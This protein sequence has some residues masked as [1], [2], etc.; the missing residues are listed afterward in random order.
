M[1]TGSPLLTGGGGGLS[2]DDN[3]NIELQGLLS[4]KPRRDLGTRV[5]GTVGREQS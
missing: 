3:E 1:G 2:N 4:T 5:V